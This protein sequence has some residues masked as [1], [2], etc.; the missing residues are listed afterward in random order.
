MPAFLKAVEAGLNASATQLPDD[1]LRDAIERT[2]AFKA[3]TVMIADDWRGHKDITTAYNAFKV[4]YPWFFDKSRRQVWKDL[5]KI[6]VTNDKIIVDRGVLFTGTV[7]YDI[8][9][10][11]VIING[12]IVDG[13]NTFEGILQAGVYNKGTFKGSVH[14]GV[15]NLDQSVWDPAATGKITAG[16]S[17]KIICKKKYVDIIPETFFIPDITGKKALYSGFGEVIKAIQH[18]TYQKITAELQKEIAIAKRGRGAAPKLLGRVNSY[19]KNLGV[20]QIDDLGDDFSDEEYTDDEIAKLLA[21]VDSEH[22]AEMTLAELYED[23]RRIIWLSESNTAPESIVPPHEFFNEREIANA[24]E[25]QI[26]SR[27]LGILD[28]SVYNYDDLSD[29]EQRRL[30]DV[31]RDSYRKATGAFFDTDD[32][33]WRAAGWTFFGSPPDDKNPGGSVGGIAVRKQQSNGMIKLVASFGDFR[34]VLKGFDEFKSKYGNSPVWGIVTPEIQKLII[35]HDKSFISLPGVVVKAME[36]I[37]RK[38]SGGE[39]KSAGLN[40]VL[41]VSTP[42]GMMDKVFLANKAYANW[43][44]DSI[45]DPSNASRL[46]VPQAVLTPLIGIIQSLI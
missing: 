11:P 37:L 21:S 8:Y 22:R 19:L 39:V 29:T 45:S 27:D 36:G 38:I 1:S 3:D 16:K 10:S 6:L 15:L 14:G 9:N 35:K 13:N 34:S 20:A 24:I 40:G 42:A 25:S 44:L 41:K 2:M 7:Y 12:G 17:I 32:F 28:E 31:F 18:G 43:L 33:G 4:T 5:P 26:R 30:F 23:S 46:P